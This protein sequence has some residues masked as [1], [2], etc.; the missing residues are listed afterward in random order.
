MSHLAAIGNPGVPNIPFSLG[1]KPCAISFRN[2]LPALRPE[3]LEAVLRHWMA[4]VLELPAL[5]DIQSVAM[6]GK[7]LYNAPAMH[8]RNFHLLS[9]FA[10]QLAA[11]RM[12][13]N[14]RRPP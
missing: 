2:L 4:N 1:T 9:L 8:E 5:D 12:Q 7:T 14:R 10:N 13:R 3:T 6:D 11:G